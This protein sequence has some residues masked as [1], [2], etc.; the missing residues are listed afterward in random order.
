MIGAKVFDGISKHKAALEAIVVGC[1][2]DESC[3][4]RLEGR[5]KFSFLGCG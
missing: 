2:F 4:K 1:M 5:R 3:L